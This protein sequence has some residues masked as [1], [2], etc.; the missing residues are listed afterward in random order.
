MR[1]HSGL[2]PHS[3]GALPPQGE[4]GAIARRDPKTPAAAAQNQAVGFNNDVVSVEDTLVVQF[5][6]WYRARGQE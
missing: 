4:R 3:S 5:I 1:P 2:S 6:G